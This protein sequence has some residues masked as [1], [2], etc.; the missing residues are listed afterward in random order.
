MR[1]NS[2]NVT[3]AVNEIVEIAEAMDLLRRSEQRR[4]DEDVHRLVRVVQQANLVVTARD[5]RTLIGL[6]R[7]LKECNGCCYLSDLVVDVK[8]HD[9]AIG[10][11]LIRHVRAAI[12]ENTLIV[13]V[14]SPD[15]MVY[16]TELE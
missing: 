14:P 3:F 5:G 6:A 13:L 10:E 12:G 7:G 9:Q 8:Y 2:M 1:V 11:Q 4:P 15:A 16:S